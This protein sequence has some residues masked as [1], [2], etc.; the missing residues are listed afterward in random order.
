MSTAD[1][2]EKMIHAYL[3][4]LR[5]Y[6]A[7]TDN[8]HTY[9]TQLEN[10]LA[11][12]CAKM[13]PDVRPR[14]EVKDG[15]FNLGVPDFSFINPRTLGTVGLLENKK[16]GLDVESL[17]NSKQIKKYTKRN[18]N[19][20]LTNYLDWILVKEGKPTHRAKLLKPDT[21]NKKAWPEPEACKQLENLFKA[22]L[23][24][25]PKGIHR[26]KELAE[27]L[28]IRCHDLKEYLYHVLDTQQN[29]VFGRRKL[30]GLYQVFRQSIFESLTLAEFADAFAQMLGYSLFLA[31]LNAPNDTAITLANARHFIPNTFE[32]IRE[33]SGF[34][35]V[36]QDREY[37]G[38]RYRVEEIVGIMNTLYLPDLVRDL[39][40]DKRGLFKGA[41]EADDERLKRA[42]PY[43]YFYEHFLKQYDAKLRETRGVY[44]TPP[45][46][47]HFIVKSVN[48][49]LRNVFG[50]TRGLAD[51]SGRVS[52]LDFATGTGTFLLEILEQI[53][54][55][56]PENI[57]LRQAL[58]RDHVI[59]NLMGF[60]FLLA[61]YTIA[62]LKLSQFLSSKG[63]PVPEGE[64]L[65][66]YLTNTL[67]P[68][69]RDFEKQHAL[70]LIYAAMTDEGRAAH[71]VKQR[72][73]LVITGN[74]PYSGDSKNPSTRLVEFDKKLPNGNRK[75]VKR[76][77]KTF[78]GNLIEDYKNVDGVPLD[79]QNTKW[80]HDD[81]VKFIRFAQWKMEQV[82]EGIVAIIT[83]H[84]WLNNPTFRGMRASLMKTF[85]QIY[86][87]DLHG[88]VLRKETDPAGGPDKNVFDIKQGVAITFFLKKKALS[89]GV[90]HADV[91]GKRGVKYDFCTT[92]SWGDVTWETLNPE[93]PSF[94]FERVNKEIASH[95]EPWWSLKDIFKD[96]SVGL[97]T[98]RDHLT[99]QFSPADVKH[100]VKDF[101]DQP[102]EVAR[103]K[104]NLRKDVRDWSIAKA[105]EDLK[106]DGFDQARIKP[107]AY[108]PFDTRYTYYTGRSRGFHCNPRPEIMKNMLD[109][110]NIALTLCRQIKSGD[111]GHA[112]VA[113]M[114]TESCYLSAQTSEISYIFPLFLMPDRSAEADMFSRKVRESNLSERYMAA[115]EKIV[116]V[117]PSP[118][119]V[120]GYIY[121]VLH[122]PSYRL[123]YGE[124]LKRD[125]PRIPMPTSRDDF[126]AIGCLGWEL[127]QAHLKRQIPELGLGNFA[128][129][130][131]AKVAEI[132][133]PLFQ[134]NTGRLYI[135]SDA[136]FERVP[137]LVAAHQIGGYKVLEKF[138]KYRKG[139]TLGYEEILHVTAVI[140]VLAFTHTQVEKIDKIWLC[141]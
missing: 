115:L 94:L 93:S 65:G 53:F 73:I 44:Y 119:E 14:Q 66:V 69:F 51:G 111:W 89:K 48:E 16:I 63:C 17:I 5:A 75:T 13:Q 6:N 114:I 21:L 40:F 80:L 112:L 92:H 122:S 46:V 132:G 78:I 34:L 49:M 118:E 22:F 88:S 8:E 90:F 120:L 77:E 109:G 84:S 50:I 41:K 24:A 43:L 79:E 107:V 72:Q 100:V 113:D 12:I 117:S 87:L 110:E 62:H 106:R 23:S 105:K 86:V 32:L 104:Y 131:T 71:T 33:L 56:L 127:V 82:E 99:I 64:R 138:L 74:P 91:Y 47:V 76:L 25:T 85:A 102:G 96:Q 19:I 97:V 125:F 37:E 42:D 67:E 30:L 26:A 68:A 9:R 57:G 124:F 128:G 31:K 130:G 2:I 11:Q 3:D 81:Y 35:E 28:A 27:Q 60:E 135:N 83:N 108:R 116:G 136:W 101:L 126:A 1:S 36:L 55:A 45:E 15:Q 54:D 95:Y 121:A 134:E 52:V 18:G 38:I 10:F 20:I 137:K 39:S 58:V 139:C 98:A 59:P 133:F 70:D 103:A 61:P 129:G 4:N 140:N 29:T 123:R 7:T 141:P